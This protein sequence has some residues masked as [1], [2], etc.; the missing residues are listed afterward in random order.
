MTNLTLTTMLPI[1][2]EPSSPSLWE[3]TI[4]AIIKE[5]DQSVSNDVTDI[6]FETLTE[7][8]SIS[9]RNTPTSEEYKSFFTEIK[10]SPSISFPTVTSTS[11]VTKENQLSTVVKELILAETSHYTHNQKESSSAF[12]S[13]NMSTYAETAKSTETER[14]TSTIAE[15]NLPKPMEN[16]TTTT[17]KSN[18]ILK[19]TANTA[20]STSTTMLLTS[21][22]SSSP[23]P[24]ESTISSITEESDLSFS[25]STSIAAETEP[26]SR[27]ERNTQTSQ[28][29]TSFVTELKASP[30]YS[31]ES[32]PSTSLPTT[33]HIIERKQPST[34]VDESISADTFHYTHNQKE[35]SS[36]F[37][38]ENI[39]TYV[40]AGKSTDAERK[41]ST[42]AE[43]SSSIPIEN[44]TKNITESNNLSKSTADMTYLTLKTM[45]PISAEPSSPSPWETTKSAISKESDQPVSNA[46]TNIAIETQTKPLSMSKTI[47]TTSEEYNSFLTEI[48]GSSSISFPTVTSKSHV[49]KENQLSTVV[50]ELILP[51]TSLYTH[52][53]KE[54]SSPFVS[55]NMSTYSETAK[56]TDTERKTTIIAEHSSSEP[57]ENETKTTIDSNHIFE[58]TA[59]TSHSTST[60]VLSTLMKLSSSTSEE[61]TVLSITEESDLSFSSSTS[62]AAE[63]E[64]L[65]ISET[66]T[67]TSKEY[68][69]FVTEIKASPFYSFETVPATSLSATSHIIESKQPSTI[70]KELISAESFHYT[71]KQKESSSP[72]VSQS[73]S[74]Y[75]ETT[76]F[77][78]T[79]RKTSTIAEHSSSKLIENE[80]TTITE[81][82]NLSKTTADMSNLTLKTML[83]ISVE[84][85]SPSPWET[86][87]SAIIKES[88]QPVSNEVTNI[89]IVTQTEPLSISERNTPTSEE[90][91]SL[92]TEIKGFPSIS[93]PTVT[94]TSHVTK[95]NQLSTVVKEL[96]LS[97]T[98]LYTH[99]QK[100]SSSPF[101]SQNMSTYAEIA[102][103]TETE[104]KTSTIAEQNL[105]KPMENETTA[106][107]ESNHIL[108]ATA[109]TAH[110]TL[111]TMLLTSIKSSSP[112]PEE[113]TESSITEESDLSFSSSTSIAAETEPLS[114]SERNTQTSK[115]YT[116]FVPEIKASP[117]HSSESLPSTSLP[118]TLHIIERKQ[119]STIVDESISADSFHY[120][121]NQKESSSPFVSENISTYVEAARPTDTERKTSTIA[122]HSSSKPI[123]NETTA[124]TESN[125][126][127]KTTANTTNITLIAML[128]ISM[129]PSS[130]SHWETTIS[131]IIKESDQPVFNAVTNI[132]IVTQT[133]PLSF[134]EINT[135]TSEEYNFFLT[136]IKGSPSI[137]FPTVTSTSHVTKENQQST[138]VKELILP[139]TS[140][141]THNQ[142]ESSSPFVLQN[143]S[144]YSETAKYTDTER[145]TSTIA[146]HSSSEPMENETKATIDS[147]HIFETTANTSHST[148]T[149]VLSTLMKLSS[150]TNEESTVLSITEESD[151]SFSSSTSTAAE[152]EPL[153]I[154]ETKTPTSKEYTSFVTEIKASPSYSFETVPA[155]SLSATSHI[156][157]S[158]QPSTIIKEL[159]SAESFH[160]TSKQKESFSPFVSQSISTYS[161]TTKF[162]DTDRKTSTIREH[163][164]SKLIENETTNVKESN[165]LSKTTAD[166]YNLTLKAMLPISVEPSSPSPWETTI[167]AIIKESDQPVSNAV[168]NIAIETQTEPLSISERN[169]PTS[170]EYNSL[171]TEIKG[172]P[173]ISF[174]TVTS[175][176]HVTKE[177]RLSTVVKELIVS[178]TSLYT[179]NQKESSSPFVS[180]N[181]STYVEAAQSTDTERKTSTIAE[182]T[183]SKPMENE[184][185]TIT[186][187]NQLSKTTANTTNLTLITMLP[188]SMEPS[189]PSPWETTIS[190]ISKES[191][192]P[193]SNAV[194]NIAIVTQTKPLSFSERNAPTSE[195]YNS[196]LT[197]IK[198]SPSFS[199]PT[200]TSTSHVTKENQLSTVLKELILPETSYYTHNQKE[201]SSP[202]ISQ[203]MSTFSE[204]AKYTDTE[205]KTTIIEEHS[206]SEPME[207][208]TKATIES[209]HIFKTTANTS[210]STS[211]I[212]L[213]TLSSSIPE[214]S[215]VLSIT[216]E[217]DLPFSSSTSIAIAA[218]TE[219]LSISETKTPTS[220]EYTSFVTEIKASPSFSATSHIIESKQTSMIIKDLISAETFHYTHNQKESSSPFVSQS[221][222]TYSERAKFTDTDRKTSTI[223]EHSSSKLIENETTTVTESNN[224]SKTT[225]HMSNLTLKTMLPISVEHSSPSPWETTI[226]AIIKESDQ[227]V[228]NAVTNIAIETQTEPSSISERNTPT[229][230]ENK[231]F[232]TEIKGSPSIS[233]PTVI[234]TSHV[235]KENQLSTVVQELILSETSHYTHN[236]RESPPFIS[237]NMSSYAETA[238]STET[239][240]KTST[241]AEQSLSKPME[242]EPTV[243]E[244]NHI[245]KATANMSHSI[246]T[247]VLPTSMKLSS[248]IPDKS[249]VSSITEESDL[250]FSSS[251][252][253]AAKTEPLSRSERN[254]QTSK[255][256]T[257]FVPEIKASPS[258]SSE[259]LPSTS[260]PTTS[261]IIERKQ[262]STI[263]DESISADSF[264]YTHNQKESSSP[265]VS[266]N[267]S[268]YEGAAQSTDTERKTST[269]AEHSSS[270][271]M[272]NGTTTVTES[273]QLSKT[274]ADMYNLT[275]KTMLPIS[276]EPSSPS[277]WVT[278]ISSLIKE[279]DQPVSNAVTKIAIE[280]QTEPLS[281]SERNTPTSREYTSFIFEKEA[282]SSSLFPSVP[283]TSVQTI[284]HVTKASRLSTILEETLSAKRWPFTMKDKESSAPFISPN[285]S[286]NADTAK[287]TYL[288]KTASSVLELRSSKPME[289]ETITSMESNHIAKTTSEASHST[290]TMFSST[291]MKSLLYIP[292]ES[293]VSS[294]GKKSFFT[295]STNIDIEPVTGPL[296]F[297]EQNSPTSKTTY[298]ITEHKVTPSSKFET[299]PLT[300]FPTPSHV[301]EGKSTIVKGSISADT[302]YYTD[303]E[304]ELSSLF[305]SQS[306]S[307]YVETPKYTD[308]ERNET[309]SS[310][311][312]MS[313]NP[314]TNVET[315][316]STE[317]ETKISSSMELSSF[318]PME[319]ETTSSIIESNHIFIKTADTPHS[320]STTVPS[321]SLEPL[322]R[323]STMSSIVKDSDPS[324]SSAAAS[325]TIEA[326]TPLL[327]ISVTNTPTYKK[328]T[329]F[330]TESKASASLRASV[331]ST[332]LQTPSL[333]TVKESVLAETS[334]VI[335]SNHT[336]KTTADASHSTLTTLLSTSLKSFLFT[337]GE[338]TVS[339][340]SKESNHSAS[341]AAKNMDPEN[342]LATT[343][344]NADT[345]TLSTLSAIPAENLTA[346]VSFFKE[347][348]SYSRDKQHPTEIKG[349]ISYITKTNAKTT[350]LNTPTKA[351]TKLSM[352]RETD[353][354]S[355]TQ[356]NVE[357]KPHTRLE[358]FATSLD[359]RLS[360]G[361]ETSTQASPI[362]QSGTYT[363]SVNQKI[364][365]TFTSS[366]PSFNATIN[367]QVSGKKTEPNTSQ[368]YTS[369][370][371]TESS[372]T[373]VSQW[374]S[375]ILTTANLTQGINLC[376]SNPCWNGATCINLVNGYSCIC[377]NGYS[378]LLC[379]IDMDDCVANP[380]K[381]G[382][383]CVDK[384]NN[385]YCQCQKGWHGIHCTEDVDEC[386]QGSTNCD[387]HAVCIN[388][389]GSYRC[390]C[391]EGY[392]GDGVICREIRLFNYGQRFG[393]K[394]ATK[395]S[396]DFVSPIIS[397]PM[398]FPFDSA[399][400][401]N[402][403]FTDNGVIIFQRK[404]YDPIYVLSHP[405]KTF[406]SN[407]I[408]SPPVIA[409]FWADADMSGGVGDLYY[410]VYYFQSSV[411]DKVFKESVE[412]AINT[413]FNSS[414]EKQFTALWAVKI[415]WDNV[416]PLISLYNSSSYSSAY[417][418]YTNT[419]Q[420]ILA[421][422]GV[423]SFSLTL[424]EDGGMK[425][426]YNTLPSQ[427]P[428]KMGYF[429]G[430]PSP[431]NTGNFPAFN[432]PHTELTNTMQQIY[433][434]DQFKGYN[435]GKNG[436]W[437]YRL[438]TNTQGT[439][440]SRLQCLNWFY[441]EA[442]PLSKINTPPCPCSFGQATLDPSFIDGFNIWYYGFDLKGFSEE[443]LTM[444]NVFP[445]PSGAGTRCYYSPSGALIFGEKEQY[446][447]TPWAYFNYWDYLADP[448]TYIKYFWNTVLPAQRM[449]YKAM[450]I[451]PYNA[452]CKYSGSANLCGLYREKRPLDSCAQ[453]VPPQTGF[454][455]GDPHI[456][457][458]DGV[459]Y[460]FNGLGEFTLA[461][462]KDENHNIVFRLQ[463]R[464]AIA[465]NGNGTSN[466]TY[467]VGLAAYTTSGDQVQWTLLNDNA[468][469]LSY[470]GTIIPLTDNVTYVDH[471]AFERTASGEVKASFNNGIS[472]SV[473]ATLGI[474]NFV[475]TLSSVHHNR[476]E[477]LLGLYNGNP[478]DDFMFANGNTLPYNGTLNLKESE[479]FTY[480]MTWKTTPENSI[481]TYDKTNNESWYTYNNNT[482]VPSFFDELLS[483][484]DSETLQKA[485]ETCEG[486]MNCLFDILSTKNFGLGMVTMKTDLAFTNQRIVMETFPPNI[487]GY[488]TIMTSLNVKIL[489]DYTVSSGQL[490]LETTS[491]DLV[492]SENGTLTWLPTSSAPVFAIIKANNSVAAVELGLT[493]I[494]CN[495]SNDGIC[496]FNNAVPRNEQ[497]NSRFMTAACKCSDSWTGEFCTEDFDACLENNCFITSSCMDNP[498]PLDGYKCSPCPKGLIGDGIKC[499][500]IDECYQ[501]SSDCEQICI[502]TIKGYNCSCTT[503]YRPDKLNSFQCEDINECIESAPCA[504]HTVCYNSPG[505]YSCT[506]MDGYNGDPYLLCTD[507]NEC[508]TGFSNLCSN[509]SV[510]INTNGSYYCE[511]LSGYNGVNCSD[512]VPT[513]VAPQPSAVILNTL[514]TEHA[515]KPK[516]T[517]FHPTTLD[518]KESTTRQLAETIYPAVNLTSTVDII[519]TEISSIFLTGFRG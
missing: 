8:L 186:E 349:N 11:H 48:K 382:A 408:V 508:T 336:S 22:K 221:I 396:R 95:E 399:F 507:I 362:T 235:S 450:E 468:T 147:N 106:T 367:Q 339:F 353:F 233:F 55:Q 431:Q 200:V 294:T 448:K 247:T 10:G 29:H 366:K 67:P 281:F 70:I 350:L 74:T 64:P 447:P 288:K 97:E 402:L 117:S 495:C 56:Y 414:L 388:T 230:E 354:Q 472:I 81:S 463:G 98:S 205:R 317:R 110:S 163:S 485:N 282:S 79:D 381:N 432:D 30:S 512:I 434:P 159:I 428:P 258:Y 173:S 289:D 145:K 351:L 314:F 1:S 265:F 255:E 501:N 140:L 23:I 324:T 320:T 229:S 222:S 413:Y 243:V 201:S 53:Q 269:I 491:S 415:T 82:N 352:S 195:E 135:P 193:V 3:T 223:A 304:N 47:T 355:T 322:L 146:E 225:E 107:I 202:F 232:F 344:Q 386:S 424:F 168:T 423:H 155:T 129:E 332:T 161:E 115:E 451:D 358:I 515:S 206:S 338:T 330:G 310:S 302:F 28:E 69:S 334:I 276:M 270:K 239:E 102:K 370:N 474:L 215:T 27:S 446:L 425:W 476:T 37:V 261:H 100:E 103:S 469:R 171:I 462:I 262:P 169:T 246:S 518:T 78:D 372:A 101:N 323:I 427:H 91:N 253:I 228:S 90:Y 153:S 439:V 5:S 80:T 44:E 299:I 416:L 150:S 389:L 394:K 26:L 295:T 301:T 340:I 287:S 12:I 467:F 72:F 218:K 465:G 315:A 492:M 15:Q 326:Q 411:S 510:C 92:I 490:F 444:Q 503:G 357:V 220:K 20:Y 273:N 216:E 196:F 499:F 192:Q 130:P 73:I 487:S 122:E 2:V 429:S 420:V 391:V 375:T 226:S 119:I 227:P 248:L 71:H 300:S 14:K 406:Q 87:I 482:F 34:I 128:P 327:S 430:I 293:T 126:L 104:R 108:K 112:I 118:T 259:S 62:T 188:I 307:T 274:T 473:T 59:N 89:A 442:T 272:E 488:S 162:T 185:T 156:I 194:T 500:D 373:V 376:H 176:S 313:Q 418:N 454:L 18:H 328:Y 60:I 519:G 42:I 50:K 116:S 346:T 252:N 371:F 285:T 13:K 9:E 277:P 290:S 380:C 435:T 125:Q 296:S 356:S 392:K 401:N 149:I 283:S 40:E 486:N 309:E 305:T 143:K 133:E 217:S 84:P 94:S 292:V 505:N 251:T 311:P 267:I 278:K 384:V 212:V 297:S 238:K 219:P 24:E 506:C 493:L 404:T 208:E 308:I 111:T 303:N 36:P 189:S 457:T 151:L 57:M 198:R 77:S 385:F 256:Y 479:L 455:F 407:D 4:S 390:N 312:F 498:A 466:A 471:V 316:R 144:T 379:E 403:Y 17:I 319:E 481:F 86:T 343:F 142:K 39:S 43:H 279:S 453:Y 88:D 114:I 318:I 405:Y 175:T 306:L 517:T 45:L 213:S 96:I 113:S 61:S 325:I 509:T 387:K 410:Q 58:T 268:T 68:T 244:S 464:T 369:P 66:K 443:Y 475:L 449:K 280:T 426:R 365:P 207:N 165:N 177:N 433:A 49:T 377:R 6:A 242:N 19:A 234:S 271:L 41:T 121:H 199:F 32:L 120:T 333:V 93:F 241:I 504:E 286:S 342:V 164:S 224:L 152:I 419:F 160:Y 441:E 438:D 21:L 374:L 335:E 513:H 174:P 197:E 440:N 254:T 136:E 158:K 291:S 345:L 184:T 437:A 187:S 240:R 124:I 421:T 368:H 452:C 360:I 139:E 54:S 361:A 484:S 245:V 337:P 260:L 480:G 210:H 138:V 412:K 75:S 46:V 132:A 284:S 131:S 383:I 456:N 109:S 436:Q 364:P 237:Q 359:S 489:M 348:E 460:T 514:T 52:N 502:N 347:A 33:S 496:D 148:S 409:P 478:N 298:F 363:S 231:S 458:L 99:N 494:L 190:S 203:N 459:P 378:G 209:N 7:P 65:S 341:T 51:E 249:T 329:S 331:Q 141:Y 25:S 35:S 154:S 211:T 257:S 16:E 483:T 157:E 166:M 127:S 275:L 31:S 264:H 417:R 470:N 445:T 266:E 263:V 422:D 477:G 123:E 178:E 395:R 167:S 170:E 398:G 172:F 236:Q 181:I 76:K 461:N 511:C 191:D 516:E 105:P 38:S 397:I 180:E 83:P 137:S 400:Y 393:D 85:S 204:T 497:R 214:E 183:S 250:S 182:H 63:T 134:S 321:I 179:H